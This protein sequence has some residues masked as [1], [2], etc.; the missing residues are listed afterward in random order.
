MHT[1]HTYLILE[2]GSQDEE[3]GLVPLGTALEHVNQVSVGIVLNVL[4]VHLQEHVSVGQLGAARVVHDLL[5]NR[6]KLGL[7]CRS[8]DSHMIKRGER[9][10]IEAGSS[11]RLLFLYR[12]HIINETIA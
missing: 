6:T 10:N 12:C 3:G 8:H 5:H 1:P 7:A 4:P 9:N 2:V 11:A